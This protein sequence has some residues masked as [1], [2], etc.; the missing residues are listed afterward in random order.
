MST[1][2]KPYYPESCPKCQSD[3]GWPYS[4]GT[5]H[6]PGVIVVKLRCRACAHE[7][8]GDAPKAPMSTVA[9]WPRRPDRRRATSQE[10][11]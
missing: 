8:T 1:T 10:N 3:E 9:L 2:K 6:R 4:A 5:C 7:W 11:R